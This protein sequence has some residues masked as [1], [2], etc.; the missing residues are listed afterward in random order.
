MRRPTQFKMDERM[1]SPERVFAYS[2][3]RYG[4]GGVLTALRQSGCLWVNDPLAAMRAEYKPVQLTEAARVGL[5]IPKTIIA[6]DP[7]EAHTWA[8][9]LGRPFVYKPVGGIW[10]ADEG[11][12][13]VVYTTPIKDLDDLLDPAWA[14]RRRCS[15]NGSTRRT[16]HGPSSP[17]IRCSQYGST[18]APSRA[19]STGVATTTRSVTS[20]L[21]CPAKYG[22]ASSNCTPGPHLLV[23]D[24]VKGC[25]E[26]APFDGVH[27]AVG[28]SQIPL[29]WIEQ[30]RPGG[31]IVLPWHG[32][33]RIGYQLRLTV[34]GDASAVGRFHGRADYMMLREQR[35]NQRFSSHRH[36]MA[37][38]S[39]TAAAVNPRTI[40]E[41]SLGARLLCAALAPGV[42]WYDM[43]EDS[44]YSVLLYELDDHTREGSW[45]AC[46]NA[47]GAAECRVTQYGQRRLWD[48][49]SA[50]HLQ[51]IALGSPGYERF[52]LSIDP[53]GTRLWLDRPDGPTWALRN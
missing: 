38:Q 43:V 32:A 12:V 15:R 2:E 24:G 6:S 47:P 17:A 37:E 44:E 26:R 36:K 1:T 41:V 29:A 31:T 39:M 10:H 25:P 21:T 11:Q 13:R 35:Y 18:Q 50:A 42:A 5:N 45:A 40:G 20:G 33:G 14:A 52:G 51:W 4:F 46:D 34:L 27:V 9:A 23:G 16:R 22:T 3:A 8:K 28:V 49:V 19:A 53:T 30:T 48:E 7:Q